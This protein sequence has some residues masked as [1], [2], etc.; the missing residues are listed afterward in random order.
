MQDPISDFLV[1]ELR[2][3]VKANC[4]YFFENDSRQ[5][6]FQDSKRLDYE[7]NRVFWGVKLRILRLDPVVSELFH[8]TS[9]LYSSIW[10]SP[11]YLFTIVV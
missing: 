10:S 11:T 8:N 5:A 3:Y 1:V 2:P 9:I 7:E 6:P 4:P